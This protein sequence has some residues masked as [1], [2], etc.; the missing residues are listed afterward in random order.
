MQVCCI[1]EPLYS[2]NYIGHSPDKVP[3]TNDVFVAPCGPYFPK[4][5]NVPGKLRYQCLL[6]LIEGFQNDGFGINLYHQH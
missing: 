5:I 3:C 4:G 1:N 6:E 2:S